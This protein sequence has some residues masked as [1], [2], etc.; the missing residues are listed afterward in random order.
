MRPAILDPLFAPVTALPGIGPQLAKLFERLAGPL[1][2]DLLWHLPSS[3]V[4]RRASPPIKE[5]Q[6]DQIVTIAVRVEAH[7]PGRGPRPYRV[8]CADATGRLTLTYFNVKGDYLARL[9][10]VGAERVVSGRVE[11][12]NHAPQI[13]HPDLVLRPDEL[14]RLKPIEPVYPLTAGLA[15][16]VV[17]RAVTAAV[18]RAPQLPEWIDPTLRERRLWPAWA[19]GGPSCPFPGRRSRSLALHSGA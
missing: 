16:R 9:L 6:P 4:D 13:A 17:Q 18:D 15:P 12:Y 3:I 11:F 10:P 14:D 19:D 1:V 2:V 8:I 5:L 7:Q